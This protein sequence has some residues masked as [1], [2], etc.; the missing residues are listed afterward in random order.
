MARDF[1]RGSSQYLIRTSF[2][3][4]SAYPYSISLWFQS[5]DTTVNQALFSLN[6]GADTEQIILRAQGASVGDPLIFRTTT[7]GV[8]ADASTSTGFSGGVWNHAFALGT[9][10]TSRTVYLNNAGSA[11][12]T[13]SS[14]F[15]TGLS[16][17]NVGSNPTPSLYMDGRL[18]EIGIWNV[19]LD[20]DE[21]AAL[22]AAVSPM[23]IR[24]ASLVAYWP[25][26]GR[27]SPEIELKGG[28]DLTLT[29]SPGNGDH[30]RIF[31]HGRTQRFSFA[32]AA[33][34]AQFPIIGGG[35]GAQFIGA[36]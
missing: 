7:G 35:V 11:T 12:S 33:P 26:I 2:T 3:P 22:A 5:D 29:N 17:A 31:Y 9:N 28:A 32:A 14:A 16:Q 30:C 36:A 23:K 19:A 15:P 27:Y 21:L 34:S 18:A 25:L 4:L 20:A 13:A 6:S 8:D 10:S 1:I 24:P